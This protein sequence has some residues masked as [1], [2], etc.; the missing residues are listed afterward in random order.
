MAEPI[1]E[2]CDLAAICAK[3]DAEV[4]CRIRSK[5]GQQE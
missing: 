3:I 2:Q 1:A 4:R 5:A